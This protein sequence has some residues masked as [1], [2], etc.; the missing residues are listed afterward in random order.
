MKRPAAFFS[1]LVCLL[2][3]YAVSAHASKTSFVP[4]IKGGKFEVTCKPTAIPDQAIDPIVSPGLVSAHEHAFFGNKGL[5][6]ISGPTD[7]QT[8]AAGTTCVLAQDT[9][10][11]WV[12]V[13]CAGPCVPVAG[14]DPTRG[15]FTN[16]IKPVKIFAY[17]FGT[18]GVQV[19]QF[20]STQM[21]VGGDA[22]AIAP[23]PNKQM[24]EFHCGNGGSHSSPVRTA[25]YDCT[26]ANGVR[27]TDGVVAVIKFPYCLDSAGGMEYGDVTTGA[28]PVGD[29]TLGQVQIHVHYG[30]GSKGFQL[31]S[32]LS[33]ASGPYYTFHGDW[34]NGWDQT[35]LQALVSGCL[36]VNKDCGF[37]TGSNLGPGGKA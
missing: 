4:G 5:T 35:K 34:M 6:N 3:A 1:I 10:A 18:Q 27:G 25:P 14:G 30:N 26:S 29:T 20:P 24:I 28:C 37:L 32:E 19:G 17:Y 16:A 8:N 22:H 11:Y 23:W 12:P 31:G 33:F 36:D 7:L 13:A 9:A 15:P 2:A 21:L